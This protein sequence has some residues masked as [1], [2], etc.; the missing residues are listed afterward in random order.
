MNSFKD[1]RVNENSTMSIKI[2]FYTHTNKFYYSSINQWT[3]IFK[4]PISQIE[5][6]MQYNNVANKNKY[7][8]NGF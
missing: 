3:R 7:L 6:Y 1:D 8:V 4:E 5:E 2:I